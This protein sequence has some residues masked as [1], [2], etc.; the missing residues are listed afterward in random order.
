MSGCVALLLVVLVDCIKG[1]SLNLEESNRMNLYTEELINSRLQKHDEPVQ[2]IAV[3][4]KKLKRKV[5]KIYL[6]VM[7]AS[8]YVCTM[9][10]K[11][12]CKFLCKPACC[13]CYS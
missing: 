6:I 10:S 3:N 2:N 11:K 5:R 4:K 9:L 7:I 1:N 12:N 13:Y 8:T